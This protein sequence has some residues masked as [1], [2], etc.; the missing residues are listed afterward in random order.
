VDVVVGVQEPLAGTQRQFGSPARRPGALRPQPV[1]G[2]LD[3]TVVVAPDGGLATSERPDRSLSGAELAEVVRRAGGNFV[4]A[5]LRLWLDWPGPSDEYQRLRG[6]LTQ[7]AT[8]TGAT[9]WVPMEHGRIEILDGCRDLG[10]SDNTGDPGRGR[11]TETAP[12]CSGPMW[13]DAWFP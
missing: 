5:D 10:V 12:M 1:P 2:L 7:L 9:V 8:L 4:I 11:G 3:L 13:M 6:N